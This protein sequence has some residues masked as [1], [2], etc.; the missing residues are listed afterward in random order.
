[1]CYLA[2]W[3]LEVQGNAQMMSEAK[4]IAGFLLL[5]IGLLFLYPQYIRVNAAV[6]TKIPSNNIRLNTVYKN[7]L[8]YLISSLSV[9]ILSVFSLVLNNPGIGLIFGSI[10]MFMF[11]GLDYKSV[12]Q[13]A[14]RLEGRKLSN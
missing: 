3:I 14:R 4:L 8:R 1:M 6:N 11:V 9:V 10:I 2:V 12:Y 7:K 5:N 13:E